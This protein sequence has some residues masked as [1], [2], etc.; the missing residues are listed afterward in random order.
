MEW[1][2]K[3]KPPRFPDSSLCDFLWYPTYKAE[4]FKDHSRTLDQL[5]EAMQ[6]EIEAIMPNM[7]WLQ[8]CIARHGR[9]SKDITFKT[10]KNNYDI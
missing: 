1:C 8:M 9:H 3:A 10:C 4:V 2:L 5:K 7:L 6:E